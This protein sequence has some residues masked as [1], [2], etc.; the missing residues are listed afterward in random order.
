MQWVEGMVEVVD[1]WDSE[2]CPGQ[3]PE[4]YQ[5]AFIYA[6]GSSAAHA[7]TD[8]E[9]DRVKHLPLLPIW[10]PTPGTDSPVEAAQEFIAWLK[11]HK[12]PAIV[13]TSGQ[14]QHVMWDMETGKEPDAKWL[15]EA[16]DEMQAASFWNLVYGSTSTLFGQPER[17]GY[18]VANPTNEPHLFLRPGVRATQWGFN[19]P[20]GESKID[21][22]LLAK[23]LLGCCWHHQ[24]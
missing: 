5:M 8:E 2:T 6:G 19:Q 3:L 20:S 21:T 17:D 9:I 7:W 14:H 24:G 13:P 22:W 11:D 23:D 10:V 1:G 16:A 4:G 18:M 15:R 12:V